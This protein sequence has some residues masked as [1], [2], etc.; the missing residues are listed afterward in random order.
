MVCNLGSFQIKSE[1]SPCT[2]RGKRRK[3]EAGQS[4]LAGG[5]FFVLFLSC[6]LFLFLF[7]F[8]L[9]GSLISKG[10][11]IGSLSWASE[12]QDFCTI[13]QNLKRLYRDLNWVQS[14]MQSRRSQQHLTLSRLRPCSH[15]SHCS[16]TQKWWAECTFQGQGR[17]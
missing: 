4:R 7:L 1:T 6:F 5:R 11:Y 3:K 9:G 12:E 17:V 15:C 13:C 2:C 8:F 14:C 10:T 16:R